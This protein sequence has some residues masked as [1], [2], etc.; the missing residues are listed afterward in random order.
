[1]QRAQRKS[2]NTSDWVIKLL[3]NRKKVTDDRGKKLKGHGPSHTMHSV[4]VVVVKTQ[5]INENTSTSNSSCRINL[6]THV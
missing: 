5:H 6:Q 2:F 4:T 1:M 3:P